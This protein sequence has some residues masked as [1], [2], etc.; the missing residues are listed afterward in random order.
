MAGLNAFLS[1]SILWNC[2]CVCLNRKGKPC[3]WL[4][5]CDERRMFLL[6]SVLLLVLLQIPDDSWN[7]HLK[8]QTGSISGWRLWSG[9]CSGR[10]I[11]WWSRV[12]IIEW[13][14]VGLGAMRQPCGLLSC[15]NHAADMLISHLCWRDLL[16]G[17]PHARP[18]KKKKSP[19]H[20]TVTSSVRA[21][22]TFALK[23]NSWTH[24]NGAAV[25]W[26]S[27]H[28]LLRR[29]S[30]TAQAT[31]AFFRCIMWFHCQTNSARSRQTLQR[32]DCERRVTHLMARHWKIKRDRKQVMAHWE[33]RG[34][35]LAVTFLLNEA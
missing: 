31:A 16:M 22:P 21:S 27:P 14:T 32:C 6:K 25:D 24:R 8:M 29:H 3:Q 35:L 20:E 30:F 7:T 19:E 5:K 9:A 11:S 34:N 12:W 2:R 13:T 26:L 33:K 17:E 15:W 28:W 18:K 23:L 10:S 1:L 4:S